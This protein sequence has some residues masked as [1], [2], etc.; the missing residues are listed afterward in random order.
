VVLAGGAVALWWP[1][2]GAPDR[3]VDEVTASV[4]TP[5][6]DGFEVAA[7]S[8]LVGPVVVDGLELDGSPRSWFAILAVD[9]DP[10]AVW[11]A[12]ATQLHAYSAYPGAGPTE[13]PG[14]RTHD[15]LPGDAVCRLQAGDALLEMLSVPGD[16]VEGYVVELVVGGYPATGAAP[17]APGDGGA[18]PEVASAREPPGIGGPLAPLTVAYEGDEQRYVLVEGTRLVRQ[19]GAGSLTGGFSVLLQVD[20][21][22][23]LDQVTNEYVEQATQFADEP[24]DEPEVTAYDGA[25][26]TRHD[27]PGGAGGYS[28]TIWSI[29][30]PAG[31]PDWIFFELV[32]D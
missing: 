26:V 16:V 8:S 17:V 4:G 29:D 5:L 19:H 20:D 18:V 1:A 28:G 30:R 2:S 25:T 23:D 12:Y 31:E 10:A 21:D 7:G 14:C 27:P 9:G 24:P 22:A 11:A 13:A 15:L 6:P 3:A 32:N